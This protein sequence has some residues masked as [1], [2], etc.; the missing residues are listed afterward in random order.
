MTPNGGNSQKTTDLTSNSHTNE[1]F[2]N[3]E[4]IQDPDQNMKTESIAIE[5]SKVDETKT[6]PENKEV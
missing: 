1:A 3:E 5:I 2:T 6:K 4:S